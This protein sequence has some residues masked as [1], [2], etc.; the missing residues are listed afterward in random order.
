M[1]ASGTF[2]TQRNVWLE[3]GMRGIADF[4]LL[5]YVIDPAWEMLRRLF[6]ARLSRQQCSESDLISSKEEHVIPRPSGRR[7]AIYQALERLGEVVVKI[8]SGNLGRVHLERGNCRLIYRDVTG[9][10][11]IGSVVP[12]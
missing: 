4:S 1:T 3:S 8:P 2:Q 7:G 6:A 9:V 5:S 10:L 12:V 11:Q